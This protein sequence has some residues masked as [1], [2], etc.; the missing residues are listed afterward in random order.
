MAE[1]QA[2]KPL[3][4]LITIICGVA[5][6]V[7]VAQLLG[8]TLRDGV[9]AAQF[10]PILPTVL[11]TIVLLTIGRFYHGNIRHL[12]EEYAGRGGKAY[13]GGTDDFRFSVGTRLAAD[14]FVIAAQA[15]LLV[16][17]GIFDLS[18]HS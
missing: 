12:D 16:L 10:P 18:R 13:T 1:Q 5:A 2:A 3:K 8:Q 9:Y 15:L 14:F 6:T 4:E 7:A 11:F 17:T